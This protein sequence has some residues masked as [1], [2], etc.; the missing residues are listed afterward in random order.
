ML[1]PSK[2]SASQQAQ[3][4]NPFASQLDSTYVEPDLDLTGQS[5]TRVTSPPNDNAANPFANVMGNIGSS[6]ATSSTS[7]PQPTASYTGIDTLEEPV[8]VTILRDLS[9]VANK[10]KQVLHPKGDRKVLK[11]WD[12][13]GPL[14]L[15]L[16]LAIILCAK[17]PK[18]QA[19]SIFTGVFV[20]V[21]LGAAVVTLNAK[22]LGGA[23]SFFQSVCVLGYCLFPLVVAAVITLFVGLIW[24]RLPMAIVTFGWSTYASVGFLSDSQAHLSNRRWLAVYPLCLFY[25]VISWLV[26]IS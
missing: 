18:D 19:V 11:D 9:K 7:T 8:S 13:W 16:S 14:L 5:T 25:L 17:A 12:L 6:F 20:I 26:L 24:V 23:V 3:Y 4:E 1:S 10:L 22:L 15:C 2:L 21:W